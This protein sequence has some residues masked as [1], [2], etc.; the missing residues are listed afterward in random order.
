[1]ST[2]L[3]T[4]YTNLTKLQQAERDLKTA[5]AAHIKKLKAEAME[6]LNSI[7]GADKAVTKAVISEL[8]SSILNLG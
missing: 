5:K 7:T 1:M 2:T 4:Y 3:S 6:Q 8:V